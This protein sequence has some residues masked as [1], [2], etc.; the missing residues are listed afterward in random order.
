MPSCYEALPIYLVMGHAVA[1]AL[2]EPEACGNVK[3]RRLA[4]LF[5]RPSANEREKPT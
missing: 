1:V 5:E 2:E 4:Y 3:R